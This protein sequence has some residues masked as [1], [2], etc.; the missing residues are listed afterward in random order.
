VE[1]FVLDVVLPVSVAL[2]LTILH[3]T[4]EKIGTKMKKWHAQLES[5][6]AGLMVGILFL[7]LLPQVVVGST[8]LGVY[9]YIPLLSGF[10]FIALLEKIVYKKIL[11]SNPSSH[12]K[13]SVNNKDNTKENQNLDSAFEYEKDIT[14]IECIVPEQNAIF[15]A[16]ALITHSLMIGILVALIFSENAIE[17]SFIILIPFFIRAFTIGFTTEQIM[18]NL[19]KKPEKVFRIL[20]LISPTFGALFGI[21]LVF[22]EIAFFIIFAFALGLVL[23]TI[24]RDMIPLGKKGKPVFFLLGV[25][26]TICIFLLNELVLN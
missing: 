19:N 22:N 24:I 10:V 7:E 25:I 6:G 26:F 1:L 15:E 20:G 14:E 2:V 3:F 12:V 11:H 9:I 21:F 23:F 13:M 5:L 18:E 16:I 8:I 4:G 17:I